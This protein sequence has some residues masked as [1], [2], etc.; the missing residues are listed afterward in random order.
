MSGLTFVTLF[1]V[2]YGVLGRAGYGRALALGGATAAGS[3]I[4][5]SG[6]AI[7][8][9][10]AV[11][12]GVVVALV[13]RLLGSGRA[14][15]RS[16]EVLPPATLLLMLFL[17]W[18]VV[19]TLVA[20][21]LFDGLET[22]TPG[23]TRLV[24][25][26]VT[27]SNL[28]QIVYLFLGVCVVVFLARSP[29]A[30][31]ELVG[32]AAGACTVLSL[33]R[34]LHQL[35]GLPFPEGFFDNSP[36][37]AYIQT[38]A[39]NI[40]RFRG[41]LSE[42]SSLAGSSLVTI[43]Y[44]LP[45]AGMLRGWR[46]FAALAL[47]GAAFYLGIIS[48]SAT[49]VVAGLAAALLVGGAGLIGFLARRTSLSRVLS[50]VG[51]AAVV[52]GIWVLPTI[53]SFV[54]STINDKVSSASYTERSSANGDSLNIFLDTWGF[55]VGLG[56]ARA[57]S[58]LPT[59]LSA[60]GI[61]GSL[62]FVA[63]VATLIY[64]GAAVREYRPVLWAL[65]TLLVVKIAAGPDLSD[66]TGVFWLSLGLLS[67]AALQNRQPGDVPAEAVGTPG[68]PP[69]RPAVAHPTGSEAAPTPPRTAL[70]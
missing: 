24:A 59:L 29:S 8:T 62:L 1:V 32:L 6:T 50:L 4:V 63:A 3:A 16:R 52:I 14:P 17:G 33:W 45:R 20:P 22:V 25:G 58:F 56:S 57:S 30:R 37:F 66:S 5:V 21:M 65:V 26:V 39:G 70:P 42:P 34:Y 48:T 15:T 69:A 53:S 67:R 68:A 27:S 12:L 49:F 13:L 55:G 31:P 19:V 10:Y 40:P 38:A 64:R 7:P 51:C 11:A 9:F 61:I 36:S 46:Q 2:V 41:I 23:S 35:A 18:S 43:A 54:E 28:A 47:A 44:M 60:T